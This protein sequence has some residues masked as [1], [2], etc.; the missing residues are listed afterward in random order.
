MW[1]PAEQRRLSLPQESIIYDLETGLWQVKIGN[2]LRPERYAR[3]SEARA[4]LAAPPPSPAPTPAPVITPAADTETTDE[5]ALPPPDP[6]LPFG[7]SGGPQPDLPI[8]PEA[9]ERAAAHVLAHYRA[10]LEDKGFEATARQVK[11]ARALL[12]GDNTWR[13]RADGSVEVAGSETWYRVSD[14]DPPCADRDRRGAKGG[15]IVCKGALFAPSGFCYHQLA[16]EL[17]RLAQLDLP[18]PV[19]STSDVV[20]DRDLAETPPRAKP[21]RATTTTTRSRKKT[22]PTPLDDASAP[23]A[24]PETAPTP[25][26]T[27]LAAPLEAVAE[28]EDDLGNLF[29]TPFA[30]VDEALVTLPVHIFIGA[31]GLL[32]HTRSTITLA[33]SEGMLTL[34]ADAYRV[35]LPVALEGTGQATIA[36]AEARRACTALREAAIAHAEIMV[37]IHHASATVAVMG[38]EGAIVLLPF[39]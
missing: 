24:A 29:D 5:D 4:A 2:E 22:Q 9:L 8:T 25:A 6:T 37:N 19:A 36:P 13:I 14:D 38:D 15:Y 3:P 27:L 35:Q 20:P 23:T 21:T 17:L 39:A 16:R 7:G 31:L 11:K 10:I 1:L 32:L 18:A 30:A 26:P 12:R 28:P 33:A 34:T